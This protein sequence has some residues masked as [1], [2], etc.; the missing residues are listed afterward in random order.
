MP[1]TGRSSSSTPSR[2][3]V[4]RASTSPP[5]APTPRTGRCATRTTA[6]RS[7]VTRPSR[8]TG[9]GGS[10]TR[11]RQRLGSRRR[12]GHRRR[13]ARPRRHRGHRPTTGPRTPPPPSATTVHRRATRTRRRRPRRAGHAGER[14]LRRHVLRRQRQ[15]TTIPLTRARRRNAHG[16]FA[17]DRVWRRTG[18][19]TNVVDRDRHRHRRLGVGRG[20]DAGAVSDA[21][22][23]GREAA[24]QHDP[25]PATTRAGSRT[26]GA[27]ARTRRRPASTAPSTRS[28]TPRRAA[29]CVF[30]GGTMQWS[31]GLESEPTRASSRRP[32]TSS[33]TWAMQPLTPD[34]ITR[35]PGRLEPPPVAVVHRHA[36]TPRLNV[37][38][39]SS[40]RR[41]RRDPDGSI[42]QYE[43][44]LDGNGTYETDTGTTRTVQPLV[45]HR[46][47]ARRPPASHGQRRRDRSHR[48][49]GQRHRESAADRRVHRCSESRRGRPDGD[50]QRLRLERLRRH[51]RASTS[52]TWTGTARTRSTAGTSSTTDA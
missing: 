29:R 9:S 11:Q 40:T 17:G 27:S 2:P 21:T 42:A 28:S 37:K 31:W 32:T 16:E 36:D 5:S 52:G 47:R 39:S 4:T 23:A 48:P 33:P 14:A 44:D 43:W 8:A 20:P 34:G 38:P 50:L 35:R 18:L 26:R 51:D 12:L 45:H 10:G 7:S 49:H 25:R 1:S 24:H 46:G 3:R 41:P 19:P 6:A 15:P 13:C 22:A 30:A